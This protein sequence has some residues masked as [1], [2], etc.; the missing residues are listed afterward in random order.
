MLILRIR[1]N[2]QTM[3]RKLNTQ[4]NISIHHHLHFTFMHDPY[5]P[6]HYYSHVIC[7]I[8]SHAH[9]NCNTFL[10][11][12]NWTWTSRGFGL[13]MTNKFNTFL[14]FFSL[15]Y[16]LKIAVKKINVALRHAKFQTSP[17]GHIWIKKIIFLMFFISPFILFFLPGI[18]TLFNLDFLFI[19]R[20]DQA[21]FL[22]CLDILS[23]W[24]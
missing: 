5:H 9:I 24:N 3:P 6:P 11:E 14:L 8:M 21:T 19:F 22:H 18:R 1:T 16:K 2:S 12:L 23:K 15:S 13:T 4:I 10:F 7:S 20:F 17:I